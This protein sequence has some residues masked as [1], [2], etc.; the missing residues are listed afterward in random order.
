MIIDTHNHI[1]PD[2]VAP[3][4]IKKLSEEGFKPYG[5]FTAQGLL[6]TMDRCG[7]SA[8]IVFNVAERPSLVQAANDFLARVCDG[9]KLFGMGTIHPDYENFHDELDRC[10]QMG[11]TGVK[12]SSLFQDFFAD[13]ERMLRIYQKLSDNDMIAYFH[14]GKDPVSLAAEAKTSPQRLARVLEMFPKLKVVAAHFGGLEMLKEAEKYLW[15]KDL[16]LDTTWYPSLEALNP[17]IITRL[18]KKH[19]SEKIFFGTDYPFSDTQKQIDCILKLPIGDEEKE[20]IL[21][22]NANEFFNLNLPR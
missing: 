4:I 8:A 3:A 1:C 16:Y 11:L 9:Q 2:K 17:D 7:I 5:S 12:F 10:K 14:A 21:W 19:G 20:R 13:E 22:K 15:G 6:S 18:I